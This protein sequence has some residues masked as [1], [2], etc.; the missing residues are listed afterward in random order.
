M[1]R[2]SRS[3]HPLWL[4]MLLALVGTGLAEEPSPVAESAAGPPHDPRTVTR[5]FVLDHNRIIIEVELMSADGKSRAAQAWV[6]TGT[7]ALI[8]AESAAREIGLDTSVLAD[9]EGH[10]SVESPQAAPI[11]RLGGFPL[12]TQGVALR[13]YPG[14][15]TNPGIAAEVHLPAA[16]LRSFH[17]V[18]DYPNRQ[19]TVARPGALEPRGS[20]RVCQVDP[21]TGLFLTDAT[22][23]GESVVLGVD[24]GSAGTWVS[25][26][27]VSEWSSGHPDWP[28]ATGAAGSTNFFGLDLEV[29]GTLMSLPTLEMGRLKAHDVA[30]LGLSQGL[31]DWYSK[32]SAGAVLGFIGGNVLRRFRLEV[33]WP[34]QRCYWEAGPPSD[35]RDLDIVG[36]TLRPERDG[37][38]WVAGVVEKA[39][40]ASVKGIRAGDR[41]L[42]I[43]SLETSFATMG[44]VVDALRGKPG[45]THELL[46]ERGGQRFTVEAV[47]QL[48]P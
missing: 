41:L 26:R 43:D 4:L 33:D 35:Q 8:I 2:I 3:E 47:V 32:K 38:Y 30:V 36:L 40:E 39:G 1:T 19:L 15:A 28:I 44:T 11:L 21:N 5:S 7:E 12:A 29:A 9:A 22:I 24:T 13:I 6:D 27:L 48:L 18:F 17:V 20:A 31:F 23:D 42:G 45:N 25:N 37:S 16:V 14:N 46:L 34:E 10:G